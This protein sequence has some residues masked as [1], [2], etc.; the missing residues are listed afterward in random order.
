MA[1][2]AAGRRSTTA[3]RPVASSGGPFAYLRDILE[4]GFS[5]G[6]PKLQRFVHLPFEQP[7][8]NA[9]VLGD[10]DCDVLSLFDLE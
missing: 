7:L 3:W 4:T 2:A 6:H 9:N 1:A 8:Q 5:L 10:M